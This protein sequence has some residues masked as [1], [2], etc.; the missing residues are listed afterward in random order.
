M[1]RPVP[2]GAVVCLL[3]LLLAG[4]AT[5]ALGPGFD[6]PE[7]EHSTVG[8]PEPVAGSLRKI[9][10]GTLSTGPTFEVTAYVSRTEGL[11]VRIE[12]SSGT[13]RMSC[14][15]R[16]LRPGGV[17]FTAMQHGR[18]L[19][20]ATEVGPRVSRVQ[21]KVKGRTLGAAQAQDAGPMRM[22]VASFP[23]E[24]VAPVPASS[25]SDPPPLPSSATSVQLVGIAKE[26]AVTDTA[27]APRAPAP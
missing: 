17:S 9:G 12:I 8:P 7:D 13:G 23:V 15:P 25:P 6:S 14:G 1:S 18:D 16:E 10:S 26:G 2:T 3:V 20:V 11:C 5:A 27:T 19:I 22:V 4:G 24:P 21:V